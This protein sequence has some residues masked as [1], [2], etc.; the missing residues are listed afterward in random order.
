MAAPV[1]AHAAPYGS[2]TYG[3]GPYGIGQDGP[4]PQPNPGG[5]SSGSSSGNNQSSGCSESSPTNPPDL[6]QIDAKNNQARIYFAPAG[7][8]IS[9]YYLSFGLGNLDEGYGAPLNID[10]RGAAYYDVTYLKPNTTYT[11]KVRGANGCAAGPWSDSLRAR[12]TGTSR[13]I[14]KFYP[15]KQAA[16]SITNTV[17]GLPGYISNKVT[18][19]FKKSSI[20]TKSNPS[21]QPAPQPQKVT[22]PVSQTKTTQ[23]QTQAPKQSFFDKIKSFFGF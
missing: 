18:A 17:A 7:S 6:F 9:S 21:Q 14:A 19:P 4:T 13:T 16:T 12:T 23:A 8:N 22:V 2:G 10:A 20:S 15:K 5:G 11:F 3:A 1:Q